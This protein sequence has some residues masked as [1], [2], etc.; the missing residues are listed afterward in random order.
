MIITKSSA[1]AKIND[2]ETKLFAKVCEKGINDLTCKNTEFTKDFELSNDQQEY[3]L[4]KFSS[5]ESLE[6]NNFA[7]G[8]ISDEFGVTVQIVKKKAF[9]K[10][11]KSDRLIL[12]IAMSVN[13]LESLEDK[14]CYDLQRFDGTLPNQTYHMFYAGTYFLKSESGVLSTKLV[15]LRLLKFVNVLDI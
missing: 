2:S 6:L 12:E 14:Y 8:S 4:N 5:L 1:I 13:Q 10:C 11:Y 7:K 3:G 15:D 9:V